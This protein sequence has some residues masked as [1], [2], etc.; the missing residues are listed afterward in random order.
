[1]IEH[2]VMILKNIKALKTHVIVQVIKAKGDDIMF[3]ILVGTLFLILL[4]KILIMFVELSDNDPELYYCVTK[5]C[6]CEYASEFGRCRVGEC[7]RG[8]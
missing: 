5:H 3:P 6:R 4:L 2:V 7:I 1:M 8:L